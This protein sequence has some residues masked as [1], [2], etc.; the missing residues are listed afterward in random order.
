MIF[1][2][3]VITDLH[4]DLGALQAALAHL[5]D[6]GVDLIVCCGDIVDGGDEPEEVIALLRE[7]GIPCIQGNHDRWAV[8]RHARGEA[9]HAGDARKLALA[10]DSVAWLAAL[11]TRW[12]RTIE[13]VRVAVRHG[14]PKSDMDGICPDASGADLERWCEQ[15]DA[16]V[17]IVGHTHV[18]VERH[19]SGGRLVVNPGALWRGAEASEI[20]ML[21]RT[22]GGPLNAAERAQGSCFGVLE[23]P[24][25]RWTRHRA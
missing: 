10:H 21:S 16:D 13:G 14:T 11:P 18:P 1:K 20:S 8:A 23:L 15:A 25:R 6:L 24:S 2:L 17:L 19:V 7:R 3:G 4:A 5:D 9:A 22:G 12:D